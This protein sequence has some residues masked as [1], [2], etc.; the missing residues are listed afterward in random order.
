MD[1]KKMQ[2]FEEQKEEVIQFEWPQAYYLPTD[3]NVRKAALNRALAEKLEPE[4]DAIRQEIWDRRY[5]RPAGVDNFLAGYMNLHYFASTV[6]SS[7]WAKF[8]NREMKKTQDLLCYDIPEKYGEA[9]QEIL[10]LDLYH[11]VDYYIDICL[12]DKKYSGLLMG[13][14]TMKKEDLISKIALD[15]HKTCFT[16]CDGFTLAPA[17]KLLQKAAQQCFANRFPWKKDI[18]DKKISG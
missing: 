10:Y 9:G 4:N 13:L 3:A 14:G 16:I 8:H 17:H 15:L 12:R 18:L 6:K 11:M 2:D 7:F 5:N 1:L